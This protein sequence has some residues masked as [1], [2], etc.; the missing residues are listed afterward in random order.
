MK[1]HNDPSPTINI[2][3]PNPNFYTRFQLYIPFLGG[4]QCCFQCVQIGTHSLCKKTRERS[5]WGPKVNKKKGCSREKGTGL[6]SMRFWLKWNW[7]NENPDFTS[8]PSNRRRGQRVERCSG[9]FDP[10]QC[11]WSLKGGETEKS[12]I[13]S[14]DEK[15]RNTLKSEWKYG[16]GRVG[17]LLGQASIIFNETKH[18]INITGEELKMSEFVAVFW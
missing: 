13:C 9:G 18:F 10:Q 1:Y 8:A 6:W 2:L 12:R 15:T 7:R 16:H 17:S 3:Y 14:S 5:I 4:W 11:S